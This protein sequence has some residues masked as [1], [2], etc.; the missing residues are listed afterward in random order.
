MAHKL[1]FH[2]SISVDLAGAVGYYEEI[3]IVLANRFRDQVN[4]RL[5]EICDHPELFPLDLAPVRF[6]K[7]EHFPYIVFFAVNEFTV[8]ILAFRVY[9]RISSSLDQAGISPQW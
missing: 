3:S 9:L 7:I 1:I 2:P 5:N 8:S 4:R 6:A